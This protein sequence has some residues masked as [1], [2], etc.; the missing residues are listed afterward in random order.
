LSPCAC[1]DDCVNTD[2]YNYDNLECEVPVLVV[3][4]GDDEADDDFES[5]NTDDEGD[6]DEDD[7]AEEET[8]DECVTVYSECD[9]QGS[10]MEVCDTYDCF[11]WSPMSVVVPRGKKVIFYTECN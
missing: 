10:S 8:S 4:S 3:D 11:D 5:G 6:D 1:P 2:E 9:Y 7:D